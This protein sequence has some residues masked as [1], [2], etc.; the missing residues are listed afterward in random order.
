VLLVGCVCQ[1]AHL[2]RRFRSEFRRRTDM[3]RLF[4]LISARL[5][6]CYECD[7]LWNIVN[8]LCSWYFNFK[9][10]SHFQKNLIILPMTID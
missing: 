5:F 8:Y 3:D 6:K 7:M 4:R 1:V 10:F 9:C 2:S